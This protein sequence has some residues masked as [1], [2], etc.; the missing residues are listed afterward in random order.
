MMNVI[1]RPDPRDG[2]ALPADDT[3][4]TR[5]TGQAAE[6]AEGRLRAAPRRPSA[7]HRGRRDGDEGGAGLR[8]A[9]LHGRGGRGALLLRRGRPRLRDPLALG[10]AAPAA[11]LPRG[12]PRRVRSEPAGRRQGGPA[13]HAAGR[14]ERTGDS[15]RPH[16]GLESVLREVR[17]AADAHRCGPALRGRHQPAARPRRQGQHHVVTLHAAVQPLAPSRGDGAVR[18][19]TARPARRP[20]DRVGALQGCAGAARRRGLCRDPPPEIPCPPG[21]SSR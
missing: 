19:V 20:A 17:P 2:S 3:D 13:L 14:R 10:A 11:G 1:A 16:A 9:G 4:Y 6:E 5:K 12:A 8:G 7:R 18:P 21:E 15:A